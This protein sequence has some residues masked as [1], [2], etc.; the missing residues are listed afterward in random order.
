MLFAP[1]AMAGAQSDGVDGSFYKLLKALWER[2]EARTFK[3]ARQRLSTLLRF[4]QATLSSIEYDHMRE[5]WSDDL[6][7]STPASS[8]HYA[9]CAWH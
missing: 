6:S 3:N 4:A 7:H 2:G 8:K 1:N 9:P 5:G